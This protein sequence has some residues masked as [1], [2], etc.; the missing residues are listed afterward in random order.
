MGIRARSRAPG[1][2]HAIMVC[3]QD[4]GGRPTTGEH[5][6]QPQ[7]PS[8]K[9]TK[10]NALGFLSLCLTGSMDRTA[11]SGGLEPSGCPLI[12][13]NANHDLQLQFVSMRITFV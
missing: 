10:Q 4:G 9:E 11:E 6:Q 7:G 5:R 13:S 12:Y 3:S 8:K 1:N 2:F